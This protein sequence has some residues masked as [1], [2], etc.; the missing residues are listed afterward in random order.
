MTN[1]VSVTSSSIQFNGS[2]NIQF[3]GNG[4]VTATGNLTVTGIGTFT[5][6]LTLGGS[7][8]L[9]TTS[10][11]GYGQTW[12]NV[13]I[14][15]GRTL[16]TVYTNSTGKPIVVSAELTITNTAIASN[17]NCNGV[18]ISW[19]SGPGTGS[20]P[21]TLSGIIPPGN[22]YS[23]NGTSATLTSWSELR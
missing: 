10:G 1:S 3:S 8:V 15:P 13:L 9:T 21:S 16:D 4:D 17:L 23:I 6:N 18:N 7:Q 14:T 5:S 12:S 19:T 22:T 2:D 20:Y 11:L